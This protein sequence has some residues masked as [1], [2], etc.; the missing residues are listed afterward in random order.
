MH[1]R[2]VEI[3]ALEPPGIGEDLPPLGNRVH[4]HFETRKYQSSCPISGLRF[5]LDDGVV[6]VLCG[7]AIFCGWRKARW[8]SA[9]PRM[10]F[11]SRSFRCRTP[12]RA[13]LVTRA[14]ARLA[15]INEFA[16]KPRTNRRIGRPWAAAKHHRVARSRPRSISTG[17]G[18]LS[19]FFS[20]FFC[21]VLASFWPVD[22]ASLASA[23]WA[24]LRRLGV[25]LLVIR[26]L[27][28]SFLSPSSGQHLF[29]SSGFFSSSAF[30]SASPSSSSRGASR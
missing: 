29:S 9:S 18:F 12:P 26:L 20:S 24:S 4:H 30:F 3:I 17:F 27:S 19:S 10:V 15:E 16:R 21:S 14:G 1:V 22:L 6:L 7:R 23:G 8:P 2:V 28:P 13:L 11:S 5:R 25:T